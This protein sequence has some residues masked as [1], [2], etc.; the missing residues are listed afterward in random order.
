MNAGPTHWRRLAVKLAQHAAWILPGA[1]SPWADAM[2]RELDYIG[3]DAAAVRWALGCILASYRARLAHRPCVTARAAWRQVATMGI[4]MVLI[5]LALQENAGGKTEP[6]RPAFDEA[7]CNPPNASPQV[8]QHRTDPGAGRPI[9][10][11]GEASIEPAHCGVDRQSCASDRI[12]PG[13]PQGEAIHPVRSEH[14]GGLHRP[15]G[16]GIGLVGCRSDDANPL[17]RWIPNAPKAR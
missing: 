3:D 16:A 7:P 6:P 13:G 1:R 5:G 11:R 2:R 14:D 15:S 12:F 9:R 10:S 8:H 17:P 4:L